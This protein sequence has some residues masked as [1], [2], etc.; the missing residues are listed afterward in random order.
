MRISLTEKGQEVHRI[1]AGLYEKHAMTV[2]QIGGI[3]GD[4]FA[5]MNVSLL[6]LE[7]YWTDQIKYRL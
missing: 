5:R 1:V 4:D 2:E 3:A 7:R 6:R